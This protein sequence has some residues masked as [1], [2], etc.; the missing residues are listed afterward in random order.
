MI[1]LILAPILIVVVVLFFG[2][3]LP[4]ATRTDH[5]LPTAPDDAAGNESPR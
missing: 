1:W 4:P 3:P 5:R 2:R